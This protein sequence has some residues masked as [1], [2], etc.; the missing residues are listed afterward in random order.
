VVWPLDIDKAHNKTSNKKASI[1]QTSHQRV[2]GNFFQDHDKAACESR[3]T[4]SSHVAL[5]RTLSAA[6]LYFGT[7][8]KRLCLTKAAFIAASFASLYQLS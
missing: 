6:G 5:C 8:L 7:S 1:Q 4:C 3:P 2:T